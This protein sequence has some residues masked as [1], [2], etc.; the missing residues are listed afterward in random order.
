MLE[1]QNQLSSIIEALTIYDDFSVRINNFAKLL[2]FVSA[3]VFL[4]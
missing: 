3:N 1:F 4:W 2:L